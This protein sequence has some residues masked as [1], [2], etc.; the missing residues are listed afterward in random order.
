MVLLLW[1]PVLC[2]AVG[3]GGIF[4]PAN[5]GNTQWNPVVLNR[6]ANGYYPPAE[7]ETR[8]TRNL[9][10]KP[11]FVVTAPESSGNRY[12]VRLLEAGGCYGRS[13]HRQPFDQ[14]G[15]WDRMSKSA[16]YSATAQEA[17]CFVMHRSM[18]HATHWTDLRRLAESIE[19]NGLEPVFITI[20][21]NTSIVAASQVHEKHVRSVGQA[22]KNIGE[23]RR[24]IKSH[25]DWARE[26]RMRVVELDFARMGDSEY[27]QRVLYGPIGRPAPPKSARTEF[28][29][30]DVK[31]K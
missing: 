10:G 23:A 9:A 22:H 4:W 3:S 6:P 12:V 2:M 16:L 31:Y 11:C 5:Y 24:V 29:N 20:H 19:A 28:T 1:L 18:P 8:S 26:K 17:P 14:R 25:Y 7:P 21:R 27:M 30:P 15:D 13:G